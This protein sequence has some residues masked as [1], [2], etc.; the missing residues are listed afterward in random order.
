VKLTVADVRRLAV[1][2]QL[3]DGRARSVMHLASKLGYLQLDPTNAVARSHL[4]V[5][6]SRLGDYDVDGVTRLARAAGSTSTS[7][8]SCRRRTTPAPGDVYAEPDAPGGLGDRVRAAIEDLARWLGARDIVVGRVDRRWV[9]S[10][11]A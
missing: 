7:P 8:R 11:E 3:L 5:L 1:R 10:L 2:A 4:L 9:R 6:W